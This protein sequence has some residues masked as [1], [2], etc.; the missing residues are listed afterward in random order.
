MQ[1]MVLGHDHRD[2]GALARRLAARD[3]HLALAG[4]HIRSG[5]LLYA[6]ALLNGRG[7][8]C[9]SM[10]VAEYDSRAQLDQWL[11]VEPYVTGQVWQTV[12]VIPCRVGPTFH[13]VKPA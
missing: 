3:A 8:M 6:V 11:A 2:E 13:G 10:L 9:G 12:E 4:E 7:E 1:F 5:N